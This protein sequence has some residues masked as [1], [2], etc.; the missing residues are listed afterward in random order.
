MT[1]FPLAA[2]AAFA[3]MSAGAA[4][5]ATN[6]AQATA[7]SQKQAIQTPAK[8]GPVIDP[9]S[10]KS[11]QAQSMRQQLTENLTKAGFTSIKIMPSSFFVSAK[12]K[13]GE[14]VEMVI[15]PDSF[16]EV[17]EVNA[18][19]MANAPKTPQNSTQQ[20]ANAQ[21]TPPNSASKK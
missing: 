17:T 15:G 6:S 18:Q 7:T 11:L 16:T 21:T 4:H 2:A 9:D 8:N 13:Q 1:R 19:A 5:A 12:N 14:P 20:H 10:M 3:L